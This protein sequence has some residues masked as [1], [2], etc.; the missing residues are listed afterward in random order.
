[1]LTTVLFQ[2][3]HAAKCIYKIFQEP[4]HANIVYIMDTDNMLFHG[5]HISVLH[6]LVIL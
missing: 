1:M 2:K 5:P 6:S 4:Q 3:Y